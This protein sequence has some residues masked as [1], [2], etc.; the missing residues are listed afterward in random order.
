MYAKEE[1]EKGEEGKREE[2]G[3]R[4]RWRREAEE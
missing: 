4:R 3:G 2:K 1:R